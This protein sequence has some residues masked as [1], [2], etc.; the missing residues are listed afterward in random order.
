M[1]LFPSSRPGIRARVI[2]RFP[3]LVIGGTGI[4]LTKANGVWT[5]ALDISE[6]AILGEIPIAERDNLFVP[7]YNS[8]A[9]EA[10]PIQRVS[11]ETLI[12]DIPAG[13]NVVGP[14][15]ATDK[16][17]ARY[18]GTTGLLI[19]NSG[20]AI[21][22]SNNVSGIAE[23]SSGTAAVGI[24]TITAANANAL[25]VGRAGAINPALQ[26][27]SSA[28]LS[29]NGVKITAAAAGNGVTLGVISSGANEALSLLGKGSA[30]ITIGTAATLQITIPGT[31]VATSITAAALVVAGGVGV[32]ADIYGGKYIFSG[33]AGDTR[34][35][36]KSAAGTYVQILG[37]TALDVTYLRSAGGD[38]QIQSSG[39]TARQTIFNLGGVAIGAGAD[40]GV[41]SL[42]VT[43]DL[44]KNATAYNNPDY[45]FE[46]IFAGQLDK[47]AEKPGAREFFD[48]Y[49]AR[50]KR[51]MSIDEVREHAGRTSQ[52]PGVADA[53]GVFERC[54][55]VLAQLELAYAYIWQLHDRLTE[56]ERRIL[57]ER[58]PMD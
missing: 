12:A 6:L 15:S 55:A 7:I 30:P 25:T 42:R 9:G 8:E 45:V 58:D 20:V 19:Q 47:H 33:L 13:G 16:R 44:F 14:G 53:M 40:P 49:L 5:F 31:T 4:A 24:T 32:G 11:V 57:I 48:A 52:L 43:G 51:L 34:Y 1:A 10:P 29:A 27:D 26:V 38:V 22:D 36:G 21:D 46:V 2:T 28:G 18:N 35:H 23:M 41:G 39:G 54:D 56:M 37:A 17:I 50:G 3:G